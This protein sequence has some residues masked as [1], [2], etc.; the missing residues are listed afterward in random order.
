MQKSL[1]LVLLKDYSVELIKVELLNLQLTKAKLK[2][3][4]YNIYRS[5]QIN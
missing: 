4:L 1:F 3:V 5:A 2:N